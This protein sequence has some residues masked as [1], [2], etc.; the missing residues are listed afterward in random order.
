M[1]AIIRE[2]N[3]ASPLICTPDD[4]ALLPSPEEEEEEE[5]EEAVLLPV[6]E[7][8]LLLLLLLSSPLSPVEDDSLPHAPHPNAHAKGYCAAPGDCALMY[9][10][11]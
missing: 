4:A 7:L 3:R 1:S 6:P 10:V 8:L 11:A 5:E 9:R 2:P